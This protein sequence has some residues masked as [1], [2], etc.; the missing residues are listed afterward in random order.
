MSRNAATSLL[1][2]AGRVAGQFQDR[3]LRNL[4]CRR[5]QADEIWSFVYAKSKN[6]GQASSPEAGDVWTWVAMCQDTKLVPTWRLGDRSAETAREFMRDLRGRLP[7]R[8]Q[9]ATDGHLAYLEA[10]EE[11]FGSGVDY[12]ML[13]SQNKSSFIRI[14][15]NPDMDNMTTNH[16]E[17]QNLTMRMSMRRFARL[18]NG[19]SKKLENHALAVNLFYYHYNFVRIHQSLRVT[20]AMEARVTDRLWEMDDLVRM[21]DQRRPR[22]GRR[23][24]YRR[25]GRAWMENCA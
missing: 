23:G 7:H 24:P 16:V 12:A 14:E 10:V 15:G 2:D 17:R 9:L 21:V 8:V 11:A 1:I 19:F 6:A 13:P 22:P 3:M 18:T 20:P 25:M 5:I 4:P